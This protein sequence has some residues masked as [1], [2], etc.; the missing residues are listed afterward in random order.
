MPSVARDST[1][2]FTWWR[3]TTSGT[4]PAS[5]FPTGITSG[6]GTPPL[7]DHQTID[8]ITGSR[9]AIDIGGKWHF[10]HAT[11]AEHHE[12]EA[13]AKGLLISRLQPLFN[14]AML[15]M[16]MAT[17]NRIRHAQ[18]E[19][20]AAFDAFMTAAVAAI[21]TAH[22]LAP[23]GVWRRERADHHRALVAAAITSTLTAWKTT[24][25]DRR[26]REEAS[27]RRARGRHR[28]GDRADRDPGAQAAR[29]HP[30]GSG[31]GRSSE[32]GG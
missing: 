32:E 9:H 21:G 17:N 2:R 7:A 18:T 10:T 19:K 29:R 15:K 5:S 28:A 24:G 16:G 14:A 22:R 1:A 8:E 3:A 23:I 13:A 11:E 27:R 6:T 4:R 12:V 20:A 30:G 31:G 26:H 25:L